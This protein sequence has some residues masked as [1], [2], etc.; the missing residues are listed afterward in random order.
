[1]KVMGYSL[2]FVLFLLLRYLF[3]STKEDKTEPAEKN[4]NN[5]E[6]DKNSNQ[7][8]IMEENNYLSKQ[9]IDLLNN[10]KIAFSVADGGNMIQIEYLFQEFLSRIDIYTKS[11]NHTVLYRILIINEFPDD[12]FYKILELMARLNIK[13]NEGKFN[14]YIEERVVVF[15]THL[16]INSNAIDEDLHL[17]KLQFIIHILENFRKSFIKVAYENEEPILAVSPMA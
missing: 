8:E 2:L 6:S 14:M 11:N 7:L 5:I 10:R 16:S 13:V 12:R 4:R 3:I 9:I 1:M 15:D 17:N